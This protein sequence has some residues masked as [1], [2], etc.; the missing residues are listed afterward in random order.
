M[1]K[2]ILFLVF[3]GSFAITA[4]KNTDSSELAANEN[5]N[6]IVDGQEITPVLLLKNIDDQELSAVSEDCPIDSDQLH[7]V[8]ICHV[9]PGN[10]SRAKTLLIP[11][12]AVNAHIQHGSEK[13]NH[14]DFIGGCD[15]LPELTTAPN[16]CNAHNMD[17][18]KHCHND[19]HQGSVDDDTD[20]GDDSNGQSDD[21]T[22]QDD[23]GEDTPIYCNPQ[24]PN[25]LDCDG[26]DDETLKP[27]F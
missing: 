13:H 2:K 15:Q 9:P 21:S 18:N 24:Y 20:S 25:D 27:L 23:S 8:V 1:T 14:H 11:H 4:C 7:C 16:G 3:L 12:S 5:T 10:P 17:K 6:G 22:D 26:F 19:D